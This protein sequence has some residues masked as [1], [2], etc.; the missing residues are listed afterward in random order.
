MRMTT[1]TC[2]P[3]LLKHHPDDVATLHNIG[4]L[5]NCGGGH[6]LLLALIQQFYVRRGV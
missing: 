2:I 3:R 1:V 5:E 6:C 4:I